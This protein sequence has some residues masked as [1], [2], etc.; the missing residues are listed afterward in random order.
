MIS[1]KLPMGP[2]LDPPSINVYLLQGEPLTLVDTGLC[3]EAAWDALKKQLEINHLNVCDIKQVILTHAHGDH[4][5]LAAR[6]ARNSKAE[7]FGHPDAAP[8]FRFWTPDWKLENQFLKQTLAKT[9][10]PQEH[11]FKRLAY[12]ES[13]DPLVEPVEVTKFVID[14]DQITEGEE[15]WQ[16]IELPGH[17]PGIIGLIRPETNELITSDV[18]LSNTNSRPILY[19]PMNE[20]ESRYRYMADYIST[21]ERISEM[22]LSSAWPAHGEK[23]DQVRDKALDWIRQH[24]QQANLFI[25]ALEDGQKTAYEV[26]KSVFPR[27]LPFD[28]VKGL[29]EVISYL[30]LTVGEGRVEIIEQNGLDYYHLIG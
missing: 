28:P 23:I 24:R 16:V 1:F 10:A 29:V 5:G 25:G 17:A 4:Y 7:I 9:G 11:L 26:W 21:L 3:T 18:L 2:I 27:V 20:N 14:G 30:D 13:G 8:R 22:N 19:K 15:N 12:K 6:I